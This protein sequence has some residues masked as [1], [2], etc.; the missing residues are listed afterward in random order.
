MTN[1]NEQTDAEIRTATSADRDATMAVWRAAEL[2]RPWNDP[3]ADFNLAQ[4][5]NASDVLLA[6][7]PSGAVAG[8]VMVGFDG[9]RGWIYYLGVHPDHQR[10]GIGRQLMRAAED[11]LR[12]RDCPKLMFMVRSD[13]LATRAFYT[14]LGYETQG[15]E[16]LGRRLD[17]LQAD[18]ANL[19][20]LANPG[21]SP[22]A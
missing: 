7:D 8:T 15:V 4:A 12:A 5:G 17:G 1:T 21:T 11:W 10:Q 16:T 6:L 20:N 3:T 18:A 22:K 14:A 9:H 2:T 19:S 13:N